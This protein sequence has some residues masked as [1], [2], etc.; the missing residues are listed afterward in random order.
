MEKM[1]GERES[2][3]DVGDRE[4]R[5]KSEAALSCCKERAERARCM[6]CNVTELAFESGDFWS[7]TNHDPNLLLLYT[8]CVS[9]T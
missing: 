9:S 2:T 4:G 5:M 1:L 6:Q 8:T 3:C 7:H